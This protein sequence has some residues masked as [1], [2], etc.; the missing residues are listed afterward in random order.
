M[1]GTFDHV[2]NS[3][4]A[5]LD[6]PDHKV[7]ALTGLWGTGKTHLWE[8]IKKEHYSKTEAS[9]RPI[10]ISLFGARNIKD[11]KFRMLQNAYLENAAT[12]KK[13]IQTGGGVANQLLQRFL[14]YSAEDAILTWLPKLVSGRLIIIDD[15]ERKHENLTIDEF[16]GLLDE[17]SQTYKARFLVLLNTDKLKDR[18]PW[19]LLHEKVIDAEIVLNPSP[20]ECLEI[21]SKKTGLPTLP[22]TRAAISAL[23]LNNIR[24]IERVLRTIQKID[25]ASGKIGAPED[26]WIPSTVLLTASHYRGIQNPPPIDYIKTFNSFS[27]AFK[28]QKEE[29]T[30]NEIDWDSTLD[31]L[32]IRSADEYEDILHN[33]LQSGLLD[34]DRLKVTFDQYKNESVHDGVNSKHREFYKAVF[35]D[36]SLS[37]E[38]LLGM[39]RALLPTAAVLG[40][41]EITNTVSVVEQLNDHDLARQFL[42]AW[43]SS[44]DS[45]PEY[46]QLEEKIFDRTHQQFHP[47]VISKLN[48]MRD[49][50]HPPL[51][52]LE[53]VQRVV[54]NG[55]WGERERIALRSSSI[56]QYENA[57]KSVKNEDLRIFLSEH[58]RWVHSEPYDE[59]FQIG[60][61]NFVSA[62][63][64]IVSDTPESRLSIIITD[65]FQSYGLANTLTPPADPNETA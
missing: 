32:G 6:D 13:V 37:V 30:A 41:S 51:T 31:R 47:E 22:E 61:N 50:Q 14:G 44:A 64:K 27:R 59:N 46:Q 42:D 25:V 58:L 24:V 28:R 16:M 17:Y 18:E 5:L 57:L 1:T 49:L 20:A 36:P 45:R 35:W 10:Y 34:T 62:C 54:N 2:K 23:N 33:Y 4:I 56:T 39:A 29:P 12:V 38:N 11:L 26:R 21:A 52:L 3:L 63:K 48:S 19:S 15:I 65:A 9:K 7:I 8:S 40:P 55:G 60:A 53:T 43:L